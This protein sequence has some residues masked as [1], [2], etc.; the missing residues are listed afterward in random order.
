LLVFASTVLVGLWAN[1]PFAMAPGMGLNAFFTYTVVIGQNIPWQT[2]LGIVFLS[3]VLFLILT[4]LGIQEKLI[5]AIPTSL[6]AAMGAGIGLF[7]ALIG[8]KKLNL[9]VDSPATL[10]TLGSFTPEVIIGC[11]SFLVMVVLDIRKVRG[12]ILWGIVFGTVAGLIFSEVQLPH[13]LISLPPSIDPVLFKLD[14]VSAFQWSFIGVIFTFMFVD[15]FDSIGT[16]LA[17]SAEAGLI[18]EDGKLPEM[19]PVLKADAT[20]TILGG[21]L[22]SSTTTTYIESASG[23]AAG[24]RTG[25]TSI[26]TG[27]F[28]L[29]ALFFS[30]II[31]IVPE[32]AIAPAL[33]MVGAYMIK[34][35]N[36]IDFKDLSKVV[37]AFLTMILMPMTYSISNGLAFGFISYP[38]IAI[39]TGRGKEISIALWVISLAAILMLLL[40]NH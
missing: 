33:I 30:P 17:C 16:I 32:Y 23:I 7:I 2:A 14:I 15:L 18:K 29:V 10:I 12:A 25:L 31:S 24:G 3:G 21:L 19:N 13:T 4:F 36:S 11:L 1:V 27:V 39:V 34:Q 26:F 20:A 28:F 8:L 22:G 9:V 40:K 37:P 35:I 38:L 5:D 6:R